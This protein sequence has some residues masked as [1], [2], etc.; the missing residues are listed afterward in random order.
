LVQGSR[1]AAWQ[2]V[3]FDWDDRSKRIGRGGDGE[4]RANDQID[5]AGATRR[6]FARPST[7]AQDG[8]AILIIWNRY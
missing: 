1:A 2:D 5:H 7:W 8:L 4:R 6:C 3:R